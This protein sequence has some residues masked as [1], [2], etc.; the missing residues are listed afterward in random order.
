MP[1]NRLCAAWAFKPV[2]LLNQRALSRL[3]FYLL[4]SFRSQLIKDYT[5][6]TTLQIPHFAYW[7]KKKNSCNRKAC[8]LAFVRFPGFSK[9]KM[10]RKTVK[11]NQKQTKQN[12]LPNRTGLVEAV[13][14]IA[15]CVRIAFVQTPL[16]LQTTLHF[17]IAIPHKSNVSFTYKWM[18]FLKNLTCITRFTPSGG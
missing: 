13:L 18:R 7:F 17:V 16:K 5:S 15:S 2:P 6:K 9:T 12:G 3:L 1:L 10:K 14:T 8:W 4:F 11:N